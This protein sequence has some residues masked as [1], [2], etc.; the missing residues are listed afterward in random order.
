MSA[1][2]Q[3]IIGSITRLMEN[4]KNRKVS[5]FTLE[6][7]EFNRVGLDDN[8]LGLKSTDNTW[9]IPLTELTNNEL[10]MV[11]MKMMSNKNEQ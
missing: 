8:E 7:H 9:F 1:N 3:Q 6:D 5:P 11:K 10:K 4:R 2:K